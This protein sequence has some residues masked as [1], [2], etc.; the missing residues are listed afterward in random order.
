MKTVKQNCSPSEKGHYHLI[1][2]F[3]FTFA[4]SNLY[5]FIYKKDGPTYVLRYLEKLEKYEDL[6]NSLGSNIFLKY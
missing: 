4:S 1:I 3:V 6:Q 2:I 5:F